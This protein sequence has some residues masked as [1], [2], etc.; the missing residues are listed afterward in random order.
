VV[1]KVALRIDKH[2]EEHH[3]RKIRAT[4]ITAKG[5]IEKAAMGGPGI[6]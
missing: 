4:L 2:R 6:A 5:R 1:G 3:T